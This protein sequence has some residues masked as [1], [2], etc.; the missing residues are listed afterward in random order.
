MSA[1]VRWLAL[2]SLCVLAGCGGGG[3]S[4]SDPS[5][6]SGSSTSS[7]SSGVSSSSGSNVVTVTVNA[8]PA[9]AQGGTINIPYISVTLGQ[10]GTSTCTTINDV[11]VDTGSSG[12]RMMASALQAAGLTQAD[13][14]DPNNAGNTLAECVPFADGYT[15]GPLMSADVKIGG[16]VAPGV[17]VNIIDDNGSFAPA[18]PNNDH[19]ATH[20]AT[21]LNSVTAFAANGVLGVGVL[22]QDCGSSC[23]ECASAVGGCNAD[24]DIYYSCNTSNTCGF[25]PLAPTLQVRNPVALFAVD[26][27]GVIVTLPAIPAAG[28]V[29]ASGSLTFGIGT[30]ANN[31]LSS[32]AVV[33]TTDGAGNF[34]TTYNSQT[35]SSSFIDSGSNALYFPN[36][37]TP[38]TM[39]TVC[40]DTQSD[41]NAS[42]F[43]CPASPVSETAIN[44]GQNGTMSTV[45]FEITNVNSLNANFYATPTIG[46]P[47]TPAAMLGSSFDWGLPFFYGKSVYV[48]IDGMTAGSAIGPYNAY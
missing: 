26:N 46:G 43:Y 7:S 48:A 40:P 15:W 18:V 17:S 42:D 5:N 33:L 10:P 8:G 22:D 14:A 44:R 9:A 28:Q 19:C 20:G 11:L 3:G 45:P 35:L 27:N 12:L 41:P 30:Q 31:A 47:A 2:L 25:T 23:A 29:G 39:I 32:A 16:E 36:G 37:T 13:L 6:S 21:S 24:N 34:T 38:E 1:Y 4:S